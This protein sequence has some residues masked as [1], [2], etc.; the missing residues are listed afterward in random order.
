MKPIKKVLVVDDDED[1]CE[2]IAEVL[3]DEGY[4]VRTSHNGLKAMALIRSEPFDTVVL[5]LKI[6]GLTG[7]QIL[8]KMKELNIPAKVIIASGKPMQEILDVDS[9]VFDR[10]QDSEAR[11]LLA[12]ADVCMSKPFDIRKLLS[13]I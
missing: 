11:D 1:I 5:D 12:L 2:E 10:T 3:R 13:L 7:L 6:P 4:A 8:K 9:P